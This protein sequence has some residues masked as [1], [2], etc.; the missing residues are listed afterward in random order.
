MF[1]ILKISF[2]NFL[3]QKRRNLMIGGSI[4]FG[5]AIMM[6]AN[7]FSNGISD[8]ILNKM[9]IYMTGH[10]K[11]QGIE[12]GRIISPIFRDKDRIKSIIL[13]SDPNIQSILEDIGSLVRVVGN[14]KGDYAWITNTNL[15]P[16]FKQLYKPLKGSYDLFE[17]IK[18][19][20]MLSEKKAET[21]NISIGDS[22]N[23]RTTNVNGQTNTGTFILSII[24]KNKNMFMDYAIFSKTSTLKTLL[25]YKNQESGAFKL[26]LKNPKKAKETADNIHKQLSPG[27]FG[28][29]AKLG[30]K[31]VIVVPIG[32]IPTQNKLQEFLGINRKDVTITQK[33]NQ[34]LNVPIMSNSLQTT[35]S[36][37]T[38]K[39]IE[40]KTNTDL[41]LKNAVKSAYS[42]IPKNLIF[43]PS[44]LFFKTFQTNYPE[45]RINLTKYFTANNLNTNILKLIDTE[46]TL[47]NRTEN[48]IS[49]N[50]K[51]KSLMKNKRAQ[52]TLDVSSMYETAKDV[53]QFEQ[54][55]NL[56]VLSVSIILF[57]IIM[58]GVLNSLRMTIQERY[59]E[60]GTLRAI[61]LKKIHLQ[62][63]FLLEMLILATV[64]S[65][66][67]IV[68]SFGVMKGLSLLKF[69]TDNALNMILVD[70]SIYFLPTLS[71][72]IKNLLLV[73]GF[74]L[75]TVYFPCR[76][77]A[78]LSPSEALRR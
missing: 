15:H 37:I 62:W 3:R 49:F 17:S 36:H 13:E 5:I 19:P 39:K 1:T 67:G 75:I 40:S 52:P 68:I 53:I 30:N 73:L 16:D 63:I 43:V 8:N 34:L 66:I 57:F 64:S 6:L 76:N 61:G 50:K 48:T 12:N 35:S 42:N 69:T 65:L 9:V 51:L 47:T 54:M 71:H 21:L 24:T 55:F 33:H 46:W 28:V 31:N 2:R 60:I 14:G 56:V 38:F 18:N 20:I 78:K 7:A 77:A 72:I 11:V 44:R 32:I 74:T 23:I 41:I 25:G 29:Q 45:N 4:S 26:L 58:I 70:N 27:K 59:R 22:V 10:V